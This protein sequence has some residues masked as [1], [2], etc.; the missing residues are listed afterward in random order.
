ML[1]GQLARADEC[2]R[3]L[4]QVRLEQADT[5]SL[6]EKVRGDQASHISKLEEVR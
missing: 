2:N 1:Q 5:I 3:G 6:L 4:Q